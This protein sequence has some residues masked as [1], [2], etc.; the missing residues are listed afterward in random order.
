[1]HNCAGQIDK[2]ENGIVEGEANENGEE[3][4]GKE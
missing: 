3:K 1:M 2:G 4:K